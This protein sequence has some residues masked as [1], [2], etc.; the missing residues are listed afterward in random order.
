MRFLPVD[1]TKHLFAIGVILIH[2]RSESRYSDQLNSFIYDLSLLVSGAVAGFF[3]LSGYFLK[4]QR[5]TD[6]A[7]GWSKIKGN[8]PKLLFPYFFFSVLYGGLLV[9][10]GKESLSTLLKNIAFLKGGAM[11][12]YFLPYL[13][14]ISG[15]LILVTGLT[16]RPLLSALAM[17][18]GAVVVSLFLST[19][20]STGTGWKMFFFYGAAFALGTTLAFFPKDKVW[21]FVGTS[22]AIGLLLWGLGRMDYRYDD[23][24]LAY[25]I[26]V[27]ALV[28]SLFLPCPSKSLPGSGGIYLLHAPLLNVAVSTVLIKVGVIA[29]PNFVLTVV[30]TYLVALVVTLL[31]IK[32]VPVTRR[33]LLE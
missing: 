19:P 16:K 27:V 21:H 5:V 13:F 9:V 11:Q 3:L 6:L 25:G 32:L 23:L 17:L 14:V 29:L 8:V 31:A 26:A 12:L 22:M 18:F 10:L 33:L 30:L 24:L 1:L 7:A 20:L 28:W 2:T 4:P 15:V